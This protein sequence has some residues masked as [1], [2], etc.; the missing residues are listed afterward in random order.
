[1][2]AIDRK[3]PT[4]TGTNHGPRCWLYALTR[5]EFYVMDSSDPLRRPVGYCEDRISALSTIHAAE[6]CNFSLRA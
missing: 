6:R 2:N 1:M 5:G 4:D 3:A